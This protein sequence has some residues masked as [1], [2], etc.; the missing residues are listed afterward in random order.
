MS[1][2]IRESVIESYTPLQM[3]ALVNDVRA[4]PQF[5]PHC[6]KVVV[7]KEEPQSLRAEVHFAKGF[8]HHH[9]TT[10]NHLFSPDR[11]EMQLVEGPFKKLSGTWQFHTLP[12]GCRV[13]LQLTFD[14][15]NRLIQKMVQP[16]F[17]TLMRDMV[18]AFGAR[19]KKVYG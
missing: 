13:E 8:L 3:F 4:Y 16:F 7:Q 11:I 10:E 5:V 1:I 6:T 18:K 9:F 14:F 17:E 12:A 15:D 19:A 2:N